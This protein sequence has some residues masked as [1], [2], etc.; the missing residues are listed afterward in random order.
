MLTNKMMKL[1]IVIGLVLFMLTTLN[2]NSQPYF[3]SQS[4]QN[5]YYSLPASS[6]LNKPVADTVIYSLE[7]AAPIAF[8]WD[9][10]EMLVHIGYR[11]LQDGEMRKSFNPAVVWFLEREI[12][13][14]FVADNLEQKLAMNRDNGLLIALNGNT[15]QTSF[16]RSRTGLPYLLQRVSGME[17]HY[18][19]GRR[20]RVDL[21][22]GVGQ[23]IS[24]HFVADAELLSN[25]D[26]KERD[27]RIAAQLSHHRARTVH[28][29]S[30][31]CNDATIQTLNDSTFVC[32]GNAFIIPQINDNLYYTK[33]DDGELKLTFGSNRIAETLS[34]VMLAPSERNYTMQ[35]TQRVYGGIT[36]SY[37]V[38]SRDFF[39]YFSDEYDRYFGIESVERDVLT[40]TLILANR[41][42]GYIHLV[43][44][45][46]SILDL[47][48]GGTMKIQLNANI[49]QHN[50]ETIFG[51][52]RE[53]NSE[54][55]FNINI[56]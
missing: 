33:S 30:L 25:M 32:K 29:H 54:Y 42:M 45:S 53:T 15:P 9:E 38:D 47:L 40:G 28:S 22:C 36:H 27:D 10:Y 14:L 11:F 3:Y 48:S 23:T 50:V 2:A 8:V 37:E 26:K 5:L 52:K 18:E 1:K 51:K 56:R 44:V 41:N 35:I 7:I 17:I 46:V 6:R 19:D 13:A 12:I 4:L 39:D 49:P 16:Y 31:R 20:Y 43:F 34:N 55:Q 21:H 24:F